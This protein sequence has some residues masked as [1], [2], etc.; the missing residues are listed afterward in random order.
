MEEEWKP[1]PMKEF[2]HYWVSNM[3]RVKNNRTGKILKA[4]FNSYGYLMVILYKNKKR[5]PLTIHRAVMLTFCPVSNSSEMEVNHING[6]K[7]DN[8]INNLEW[9]TQAENI[10]HAFKI[11]LK[12][13]VEVI[14][15]DTMQIFDSYLA[16]AKNFE[17][18]NSSNV[19]AVCDGR[20]SHTQG[21]HFARLEDYK[22]NCIP[23]FNG[24]YYRH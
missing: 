3:G 5:K 9:C 13:R 18:I 19:Q 21:K 7:T 2:N 10:E 14:C 1:F 15:L 4:S 20:Q 8:T 22:N 6:V 16:A 24:K 11:G 17:N 23:P 12:K